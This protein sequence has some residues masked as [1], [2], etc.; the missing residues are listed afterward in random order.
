MGRKKRLNI[1]KLYIVMTDR[2]GCTGELVERLSRLPYQKVLFS[3][4][5]IPQYDF[6]VYVP[7]FEK[8]GQVGELNR[9]AD[10]RGNRYYEKYFDFVK[11]LR[12]ETTNEKI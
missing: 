11:W 12:G 4:K 5:P 8:D 2:N 9:F 3:H 1:E 10:F 6:V 7:G